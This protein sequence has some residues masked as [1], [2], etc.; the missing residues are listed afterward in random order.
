MTIYDQMLTRYV[1]KTSA[2]AFNAQHEVMQQI[3][4]LH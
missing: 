4:V 3:D 1:V 2:D